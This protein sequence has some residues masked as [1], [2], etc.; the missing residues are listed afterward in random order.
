MCYGQ[1]SRSLEAD[2]LDTEAE[3]CMEGKLLG[4]AL[5]FWCT[6]VLLGL[7]LG[8]STPRNTRDALS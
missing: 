5:S 6:T 7:L 4:G 8:A 3:A 1:Q 2:L